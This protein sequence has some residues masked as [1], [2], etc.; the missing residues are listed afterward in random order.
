MVYAFDYLRGWDYPWTDTD[1]NVAASMA[2]YWTNFVKTLD[3]NGARLTNW[4]AYDPKDERML[5]I[6]DTNT[7]EK[8]NTPR[9]DFIAGLQQAGRMRR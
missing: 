9:M 7:V 8:I 5:K 6:G 1:R 4:P 2:A 3:P